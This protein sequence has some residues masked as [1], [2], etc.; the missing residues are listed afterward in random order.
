MV[1]VLGIVASVFTLTERIRKLSKYANAYRNAGNK[2]ETCRDIFRELCLY[3]RAIQ[4]NKTSLKC[5]Q[6]IKIIQRVSSGHDQALVLPAPTEEQTENVIEVLSEKIKLLIEDTAKELEGP[7]HFA[8]STLIYEKMGASTPPQALQDAFEEQRGSGDETSRNSYGTLFPVDE[9]ANTSEGL[10]DD[11]EI[12]I[13]ELINDERPVL[14]LPYNSDE[15]QETPPTENTSE[16]RT[17]DTDA[18][19]EIVS[20]IL[21]H[22]PQGPEVGDEWTVFTDEPA[23]I[24]RSGTAFLDEATNVASCKSSD[25]HVFRFCIHT[26]IVQDGVRH[27]QI[28]PTADLAEQAEGT[29]APILHYSLSCLNKEMHTLIYLLQGARNRNDDPVEEEELNSNI[30][31]DNEESQDE[32]D[33]NAVRC[34]IRD[35]TVVPCFFCGSDALQPAQSAQGAWAAF[36]YHNQSIGYNCSR[37]D[38]RGLGCQVES[39]HLRQQVADGRLSQ[40]EEHSSIGTISNV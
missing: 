28:L 19:V 22:E 15:A 8:M 23:N 14:H 36:I 1:E 27:G 31:R 10:R 34:G 12:D 13:A 26:L 5:R 38:K 2:V 37:C 39:L 6:S 40:F 21:T 25:I 3:L 20:I 24:S 32:D 29:D 9:S 16:P 17:G 4:L 35:Y 11:I 18:P 33:Q 7:L 30:R